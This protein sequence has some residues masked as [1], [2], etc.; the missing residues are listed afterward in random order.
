MR[1]GRRQGVGLMGVGVR[2]GMS[3][4]T[5][6][7]SRTYSDFP[8]LTWWERVSPSLSLGPGFRPRTLFTFE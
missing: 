4:G 2:D 8:G 6:L 5:R 7:S 1:S 3:H